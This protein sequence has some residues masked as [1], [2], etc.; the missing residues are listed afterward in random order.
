MEIKIDTHPQIAVLELFQDEMKK[1]Y[2]DNGRGLY[3]NY[4]IIYDLFKKD[5]AIVCLKDGR[6]IGFTTWDRW[7]PK[8]VTIDLTWVLPSER[9]FFAAKRF[10]ELV[11]KEFKRRRDKMLRSKCVT[12]NG[13]CIA[14]NSG[15]IIEDDSLSYKEFKKR[16]PFAKGRTMFDKSIPTF[17]RLQ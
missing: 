17:K 9:S 3:A 2:E 8:I 11:S 6:P 16:Y 12:L 10:L 1:E 5:H 4:S 13:L 7:E 14:E 15:F